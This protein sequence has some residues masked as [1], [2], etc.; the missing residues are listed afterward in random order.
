MPESLKDYCEIDN[1]FE[2]FLLQV[3]LVYKQFYCTVSMNIK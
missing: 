2:T 1:V 3:L